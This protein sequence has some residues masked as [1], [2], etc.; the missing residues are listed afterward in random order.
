MVA[1]GSSTV[2]GNH[3]DLFLTILQSNVSIKLCNVVR[4]NE[5]VGHISAFVFFT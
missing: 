5:P 2:I 4:I 3:A 1:Q